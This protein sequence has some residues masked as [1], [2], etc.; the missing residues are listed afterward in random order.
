MVEQDINPHPHNFISVNSANT[1]PELLHEA[2]DLPGIYFQKGNPYT[3]TDKGKDKYIDYVGIVTPDG[4]VITRKAALIVEFEASKIKPGKKEDIYD[5]CISTTINARIP[6]IPYIA[7]NYPPKDLKEQY[8]VNGQHFQLNYIS[9]NELKLSEI[10]YTIKDIDYNIFVLSGVNF[11]LWVQAI[12]FIRAPYAK[13]FLEESV[14]V[15][16]GVEN[17]DNNFQLFLHLAHKIMIKY[18]ITDEKEERRLLEMITQAMPIHQ[19]NK[20]VGYEEIYKENNY[21]RKENDEKDS[22]IHKQGLELDKKDSEI[23]QKDTEIKQKNAKIKKLV[24]ENNRLKE[25]LKQ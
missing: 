24:E 17:I 16:A 20:V 7:T 25:Q 12:A 22:T 13:N 10:L 21:L 23:K 5:Y 2:L 8:I 18:Y 9:F 19:I 1:Y 14:E 4:D 15:F 6:A 3:Y 11:M